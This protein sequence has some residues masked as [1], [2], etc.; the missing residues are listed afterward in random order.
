MDRESVFHATW[1]EMRVVGAWL[2]RWAAGVS[3]D[4]ARIF[5]EVCGLGPARAAV[6]SFPRGGTCDATFFDER[7]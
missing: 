4:S 6:G 1:A 2:S 3:R 5:D 7:R